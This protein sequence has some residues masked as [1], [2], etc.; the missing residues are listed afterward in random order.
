MHLISRWILSSMD[1]CSAHLMNPL[2]KTG[3]LLQR[4][5]PPD[6]LEGA[7]ARN[8]L[9]SGNKPG[10]VLRIDMVALIVG[11]G[12]HSGKMEKRGI[13]G[14]LVKRLERKC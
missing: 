12:V 9:P 10:N 3:A 11:N 6:I 13:V 8:L 1:P 4:E 5:V 2:V 14:F 7:I